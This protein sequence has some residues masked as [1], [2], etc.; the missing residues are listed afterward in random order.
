MRIPQEK[1]ELVQKFVEAFKDAQRA[2][3]D[4]NFDA[5][6]NGYKQ[7][8]DIYNQIS[9]SNL[10]PLHKELAYD[11]L[12]KV[13]Q[14][15]QSQPSSIHATTHIIAAA[16]LLVLFSFL[17]FF[18]PAIVGLT[19]LDPR[20]VHDLN[21]A[22]V[23]SDMRD[24]HL[25][26]VP[27]SLRISG[28]ID[29]NGFVRIYAVTSRSRILLFDDDFVHVKPDG[30]FSGAC[31]HTCTTGLDTQDFILDVVVDNAALTLHSIEY[32]K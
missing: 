5:A 10:D 28:R 24:M 31:T 29:G 12:T 2:L 27:K 8:L 32:T 14:A 30:T 9:A 16:I 13:Y 15:L 7:L 4:G 18:K 23:E 3:D 17:V 21:W 22:F 25:D 6:T 1:N 20:V 26:S 11:Q 19:T